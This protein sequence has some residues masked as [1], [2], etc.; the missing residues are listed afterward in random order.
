M[1]GARQAECPNC[2]APIEWR[3]A[4]S[5]AAVCKYC[6]FSVVRNDRTALGRVADL[7]PTAAPI[8]VDDEGSAAGKSFRVVGRI[9]L[10]HGRGPWDEWYLGF[11]DGSWG[12]LARAEGRWYLTFERACEAVRWEAAQ[13]GA[14]L[15]LA[16][17]EWV[18]T[19]RGGSAIVSAEGELPYPLDPHGSGR[20]ADLEGPEGAF[21][22]LD[23]GASLTFFAGR[24]LSASELTLKK[25]AG[26]RPLEKVAVSK[27]SCPSCGAPIELFVPDATER[28]GCKHC[29]ALLDH[30]AGTLA[31]L[32]Q[33]EP[34]AIAPL[35]PLG[36]SG[37]LLGQ[38]RTVIGFM[39]RYVVVEGDRYTFREYLLYAD[40]G[41]SWLVEEDHHWLHV[42]PVATSKVKEA[43]NA[44]FYGDTTYR[45]FARG[46][47][48]VDFVI[49][50]FYWKVM[51]GDSCATVD[52]IAPPRLLSVERTADEIS[53]SEGEYVEPATLLKAFGLSK[54]PRP[55]GVAAAQPNPH[56]ARGAALVF[57]LLAALWLSLALAYELGGKQKYEYPGLQLAT[58]GALNAPV[59]LTDSFVVPRGPTII[60]VEAYAPISN[61]SAYV[62]ASLIPEDPPGEARVMPLLIEHYQGYEGGESWSE[63]DS[64]ATQYFGRVAPGRYSFRFVGSW[65]PYGVTTLPPEVKL[66]ATIGERSPACCFGTLFLIALPY[67]LT[68]LRA[69]AFEARRKQ[70]ENL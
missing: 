4:S 23:F 41:Y 18:V 5:Q 22:T 31:L 9:Q 50:E 61:G 59:L 21:A 17:V 26:P 57:A 12:W 46:Q 14:R 38:E 54:L 43:Y 35:I 56:R 44:A 51:A 34:P 62:E 3:V 10:D 53:W 55:S 70:N 65:D 25:K 32:Q 36:A 15:T 67:L 20:Y 45:A 37:K 30:T 49:G 7:V 64:S 13:P 60:A 11:S 28:V 16:G 19:E 69:L 52:Y 40:S 1:L 48:V 58:Q 39:Q 66:T 68:R 27:L 6:R 2:G 29:G 24:E 8:A 47:P 63:G 33:L 42:T